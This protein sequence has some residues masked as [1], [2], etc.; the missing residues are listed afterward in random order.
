MNKRAQK[1]Y[2]CCMAKH[3]DLLFLSN[4]NVATPSVVQ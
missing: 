2:S 1:A 3:V 4:G